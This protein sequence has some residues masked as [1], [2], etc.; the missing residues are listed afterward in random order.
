MR[1]SDKSVTS[2]RFLGRKPWEPLTL[3]FQWQ[4]LLT[5]LQEPGDD[6]RLAAARA[7]GSVVVVQGTRQSVSRHDRATR[8]VVSF[9]PRIVPTRVVAC[10]S[11]IG[12][13]TGKGLIE[14]AL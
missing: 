2:F 10:E 3:C 13:T 11:G 8:S 9:V 5:V 6:V 7:V 14:S 4:H 12:I 1:Q